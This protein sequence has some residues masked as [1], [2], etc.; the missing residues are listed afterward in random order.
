MR[1]IG[2][3]DSLT[4]LQEKKKGNMSEIGEFSINFPSKTA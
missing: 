2:D 1:R 4:V 3:N